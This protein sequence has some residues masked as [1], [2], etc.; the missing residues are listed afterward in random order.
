MATMTMPKLTQ[1]HRELERLVGTWHGEERLYP[2]P[3][4]PQGGAAVGR[5]RNRVVLD[6][7]ALVQEYEQE[8]EGTVNF[9]G[10]GVFRWDP[11]E[12]VYTLHWF[13][14][15]GMSPSEF[16]GTLEGDVLTLTST[17]AQGMVRAVWDLPGGERYTYRRQISPEGVN[18][19]PLMEGTYD[20]ED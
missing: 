19:F 14:S 17:G 3:F 18:W 5:V 2:S 4:A 15:M 6:G 7:F 13:D 9:R 16:R 10:H 8:R 12:Q 1:G 11:G 20:R